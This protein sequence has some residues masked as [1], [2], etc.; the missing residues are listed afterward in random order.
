MV[1]NNI[2]LD[3]SLLAT[4]C[5]KHHIRRLSLFGSVLRDDFRPDSDVDMLVEFDPEHVPGFIGLCEMEF[6]LGDRL[7]GRRI[8]L[9][10]PGVDVADVV[11]SLRGR[12]A[13][14]ACDFDNDFERCGEGRKGAARICQRQR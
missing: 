7:G 13:F 5:E 8:D 10:L 1:R 2:T 14:G 11:V 9:P 6:E 12:D 3:P 4:F